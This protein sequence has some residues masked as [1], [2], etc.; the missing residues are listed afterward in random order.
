MS[1]QSATL[2]RIK[3]HAL[4]GYRYIYVETVEENEFIASLSSSME[5][6]PGFGGTVCFAA[7][8]EASLKTDFLDAKGLRRA[9]EPPREG[10]GA[11]APSPLERMK[12]ANCMPPFTGFDFRADDRNEGRQRWDK[13]DPVTGERFRADAHPLALATP[14]KLEKREAYLR[15]FEASIKERVGRKEAGEVMEAFAGGGKLRIVLFIKDASLQFFLASRYYK[16]IDEML[17]SNDFAYSELHFVMVSS[18]P[19]GSC[20]PR[21]FT[22]SVVFFSYPLPDADR[23][24]EIALEELACGGGSQDANL[25]AVAKAGVGLVE[26]EFSLCLRL[27]KR[28]GAGLGDIRKLLKAVHDQK[29]QALKT[30]SQFLEYIPD[31]EA[32]DGGRDECLELVGGMETLKKWVKRRVVLMRPETAVLSEPEKA[33]MAKLGNPKGLLLFGVSGGG[34]S[35]VAR[36]IARIF[37]LPLL[38]L[39]VGRIFGQYV[40]Q[41]EQNIRQTIALA[42]ALSPCVLWIDEIEKGFAGTGGSGDSGTASRVFGSFLTWMQ[43]KKKPVFVVATANNIG[44]I[45]SEMT[46][47]G[48]FDGF[49]FVPLPNLEGRKAIFEIHARRTI[50]PNVLSAA[51][52]DRLARAIFTGARNS[53]AIKMSTGA[54]IAAA[55]GEAVIL[56]FSLGGAAG[57]REAAL[58]ELGAEYRADVESYDEGDALMA[59]CLLESF[60][61]MRAM[62]SNQR[63]YDNY[64]RLQEFGKGRSLPV[65]DFEKNERDVYL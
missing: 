11:G 24:R 58:A 27:A 63:E 62:Y 44:S 50:P 57:G 30:S 5:E 47:M 26:R 35:L 8:D 36:Q 31:E 54:E 22:R 53:E 45:P 12:A 52:R 40:G 33:L 21:D 60:G 1:E 64:L 3:K 34:K 48:R 28:D 39:D 56:Y 23:L 14:E 7:Y 43:E 51:A 42:E 4:A 6:D 32:E 16:K 61:S 49:F 25:S 19:G 41:S 9:F 20:V 37:G 10:D 65:G 13:K 55:V 2:E 29:T 59:R 18:Y 46:R 17:S 15:A 38:R